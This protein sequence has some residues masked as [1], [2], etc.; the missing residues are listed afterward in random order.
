MIVTRLPEFKEDRFED[1]VS[2]TVPRH[3]RVMERWRP[4]TPLAGR[5][6]FVRSQPIPETT[7][8][9]L[10]KNVFFHLY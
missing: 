6:F 4:V 5:L 7:T 9:T 3:S 8:P 1:T 2:P 10:T